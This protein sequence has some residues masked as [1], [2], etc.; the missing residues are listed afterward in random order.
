MFITELSPTWL[1]ICDGNDATHMYS[2]STGIFTRE[3]FST[4]LMGQQQETR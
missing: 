3:T 2:F 1:T 4:R